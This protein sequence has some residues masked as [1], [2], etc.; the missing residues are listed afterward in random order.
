MT[1]KKIVKISIAATGNNTARR[2]W[3]DN[4]VVYKYPSQAEGPAPVGIKNV[5]AAAD[6]GAIYDLT[7]RRIVKAAKGLY[8]KNGK[9]YV[10]K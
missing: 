8:I 10:I 5:K 7:G 4:L 1:D 3:F 2:S 9:K 6:N